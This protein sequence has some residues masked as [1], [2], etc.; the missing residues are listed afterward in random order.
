MFI[1]AVL[2]FIKKLKS[3]IEIDEWYLYDFIENNVNNLS[4]GEAFDMSSY[5]LNMINN[6]LKSYEVYELLQLLL[7][8]Q[9]QSK[10]TQKPIEL[11]KNPNILQDLINENP[12]DYIISAAQDLINIYGDN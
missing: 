4:E 9:R 12:E 2:D 5:I 3:D 1:N 8:L 6:D 11:I 10:T 7:S